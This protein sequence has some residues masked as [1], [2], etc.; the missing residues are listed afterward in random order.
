MAD[1]THTLA[2]W[3]VRGAGALAGSS[4]SL[5]YMVPKRRREAVSRFV[6]GMIAGLIFSHAVGEKLATWFALEVPLERLE[7]L[8]I[9]ASAAS[10]ASWWALGLIVRI[11][12]R[13][14][15][16]GATS[17]TESEAEKAKKP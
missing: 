4:V 9:G 10:F 15:A 8:L 2:D 7:I 11:L 1:W 12:E 5:V 13:A 16:P 6:V 3:S 17:T 14:A